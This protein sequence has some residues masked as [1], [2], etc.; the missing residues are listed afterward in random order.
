MRIKKV[1]V[2]TDF[3]EASIPLL[4]YGL[5]LAHY[6][7][8]QVWVQHTYYIPAVAASDMYVPVDLQAQ[9]E[10]NAHQKFNLIKKTLPALQEH[11]V[12]FVVSYGDLVTEMNKLI[13]QEQINLVVVGNQGS[14]FLTN[15]LGSN[16]VKVI[17][18]AHCPV[19]SVPAKAVFRPFRR[20]ALAVDLKNT[21]I[22]PINLTSDIARAFNARVDLIHISDAPVPVDTEQM[23]K[24]LDSA[25][26]EI[27]HH[28]FH[29]HSADIEQGIER[30][31]EG[32]N[33][34]L[35]VLLP[36]E[37]AFFD[38]V[39]QR[40]ISQRIAYQNKIPLLTIHA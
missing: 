37:H 23:T 5:S 2:L 11:N 4:N 7:H 26:D 39:F 40:S 31:L 35:I 18:H 20:L 14:G 29:V 36:R 30:H 9:C 21:A 24:L 16:T 22:D 10:E 38:R 25:L 13:D 34:D 8:A 28:F 27:V 32:N 12:R 6:L 1:L 17:Q 19:L 3:S 15:I 33:N